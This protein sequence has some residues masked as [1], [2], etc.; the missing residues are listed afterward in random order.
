MSEDVSSSQKLIYSLVC[1]C[2][3]L[4]GGVM[5]GLTLGLMSLDVVDLEVSPSACAL[6]ADRAESRILRWNSLLD[7]HYFH[8]MDS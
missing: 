1:I 2:L 3:V 7:G 6:L 8:Q 5:S 4:V